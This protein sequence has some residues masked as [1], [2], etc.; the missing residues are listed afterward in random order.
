MSNWQGIKNSKTTKFVLLLA[1]SS[2]VLLSGCKTIEVALGMRIKLEKLPVTTMEA[3][4]PNNPGIAPGEKSP[5]VVTFTDAKGKVYVTEGKGKGKV[6]WKD[7]AITGTVVTINGKKGILSLPYDPRK[8]DGKTGHVDISAPSHPDLHAAFDIPLR[9]NIAFKA[10]FS[11]ADG[12]SGMGGSNGMDGSAGSDGS[13]DPN[14]PSPGG[15]GTNG[16]NGGDGSPGGDGGNAPPVTVQVTLRTTPRTLLQAAVSA[17]GR[18][19][20]YYLVDP[21][22]GTLNVFTNGGS[23][24]AGGAGGRGGSGGAGGSGTPSGSSGSNGSDGMKGQDGSDGRPGPITVQYDP[25]V[26]PY[27]N[28]IHLTNKGGPK[29]TWTEQSVAPLW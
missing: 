22:G 29:P 18:K 4:L 21:D 10:N 6:M 28:L 1:S 2:I 8:T 7:I 12:S 20:Y 25:S 3:T 11:G 24:G 26:Q 5:L 17:P 9:Y 14:N 15:N 13:T 27:L 16:S 23:G 19:T